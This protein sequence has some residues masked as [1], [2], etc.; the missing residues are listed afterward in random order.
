ERGVEVRVPHF[1]SRVEAE[2]FVTEKQDWIR[3]KQEEFSARPTRHEPQFHWGSRH[4]VL[5]EAQTF[6]HDAALAPDILLAGSDGDVESRIATRISHWYREECLTLFQERHQHWREQLQWMT[7]PPAWVDVRAMK[8][9]WGSCRR[10]G[11]IT[12]NTA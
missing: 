3:R 12:L 10:N 9:R 4:F 6:H 1:V 2:R 8:R 7:L 5:G 11:R